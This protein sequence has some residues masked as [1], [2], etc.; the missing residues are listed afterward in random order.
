MT[1]LR[2]E[3]ASDGLLTFRS[4][5]TGQH[6]SALDLALVVRVARDERRRCFEM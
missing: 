5:A 2:T 6:S 3:S 4:R 1:D